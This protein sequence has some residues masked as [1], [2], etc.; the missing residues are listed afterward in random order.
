M[1]AGQV[2]RGLVVSAIA[3]DGVVEA[4]EAPGEPFLLAVQ[5][6]PEREGEASAFAAVIRAL[7]EAAQAAP[8]RR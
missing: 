8:A 3:P 4:V 1:T 7:V 2:A 5:C 6:H